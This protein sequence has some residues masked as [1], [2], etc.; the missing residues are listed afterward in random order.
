LVLFLLV[1]KGD[2][3]F[4]DGEIGVTLITERKYSYDCG[5]VCLVSSRGIYSESSRISL[6][7]VIEPVLTT[8]DFG[9]LFRLEEGTLFARIPS[10]ERYRSAGG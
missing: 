8:V 1:A 5:R 9:F 10:L 6:N 7:Q 2:R 4:V 3:N